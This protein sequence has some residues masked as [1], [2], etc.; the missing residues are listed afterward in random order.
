MKTVIFGIWASMVMGLT[1][2]LAIKV[3]GEVVMVFVLL[4]AK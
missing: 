4:G 2:G 3:Y 1:D